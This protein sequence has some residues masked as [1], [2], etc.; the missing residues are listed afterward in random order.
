MRKWTRR[1]AIGA[2]LLLALW[3]ASSFAALHALRRRSS[4][5]RAETVPASWVGRCEELRLAT[6]DGEHLGAWFVDA[7]RASSP[8]VVL[9]HGK[10]GSRTARVGAAEVFQR[11]GCATLLLTHRAHGDST[12]ASED[13]GWSARF[14][15][16]AAV[17][18]AERRQPGQPILLCGAS[19]G[20][21]AAVF[22]ARELGPRVRGYWLECVYDRLEIAAW[23]R[24]QLHL[25]P[26]FDRVA[27]V[28]LQA[29][30]SVLWPQW[31]S[32]APVEHVNDIP[33][34]CA[35]W[36]LAGGADRHAP[37]DDVRA[38]ATRR[39]GRARVVVIDGAEH[40]RL[41][42]GDPLGY[43][44]AALEFLRAV[45]HAPH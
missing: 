26:L 20:G 45:G 27:F 31:S 17:E 23:R 43:E 9:L 39:N 11:L 14:D 13:F 16:L 10:G 29:A 21:A 34:E 5:P 42:I 28:G 36:L 38:L 18:W 40:D 12:G 4:P 22:A 15:V 3:I 25:P 1:V 2:A 8:T 37:L 33:D 19:L 32:I 30:A 6:S 24:C 7:P 41:L 44:R 35:L